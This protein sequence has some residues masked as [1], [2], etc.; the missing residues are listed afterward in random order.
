MLSKS[1]EKD[2]K[3]FAEATKAAGQNEPLQSKVAELEKTVERILTERD[4][5]FRGRDEAHS[6]S[7]RTAVK[8]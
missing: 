2:E 6:T 3:N 5:A 4:D 8:L 1:L 7:Q